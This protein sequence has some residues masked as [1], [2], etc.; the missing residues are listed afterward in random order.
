M[1]SVDFSCDYGQAWRTNA[2]C[3]SVTPDVFF[4]A[5]DDPDALQV[6]KNICN[7]CTVR[8]QCLY[9]ALEQREIH[10]VWGGKSPKERRWTRWV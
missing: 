10:G 6:A 3:A 4:E 2:H 8:Q 5:D 1:S 9:F 7:G